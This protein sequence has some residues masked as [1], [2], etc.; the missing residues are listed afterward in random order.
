MEQ[1]TDVMN[2]VL[3]LLG[4]KYLLGTQVDILS[5]KLDVCSE[6]QG[7]RVNGTHKNMLIIICKMLKGKIFKLIKVK[8]LSYVRYLKTWGCPGKRSLWLQREQRKGE[9]RRKRTIFYT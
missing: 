7:R 8:E 4:V 3:I 9:E 6:L 2:F 1:R 5:K